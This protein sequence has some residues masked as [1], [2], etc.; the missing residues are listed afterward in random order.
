MGKYS[1]RL[2]TF[3]ANAYPGNGGPDPEFKARRV[4]A[5]GSLA[6]TVPGA[7]TYEPAGDWSLEK[8]IGREYGGADAYVVRESER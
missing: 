4:N 8:V 6:V 1:T 5:T 3:P 7:K 2:A